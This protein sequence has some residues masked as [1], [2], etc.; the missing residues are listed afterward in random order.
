[1]DERERIWRERI[2]WQQ[3]SGMT[4]VECCDVEG[5]S[6]ASFYR[7]KKLIEGAVQQR[8]GRGEGR[9]M[10]ASSSFVPFT[11]RRSGP[12]QK[13]RSVDSWKSHRQNDDGQLARG[14]PRNSR[15]LSERPLF[16][17]D[18]QELTRLCLRIC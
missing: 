15:E 7:C 14:C 10:A 12:D 6:V 4:V 9:A 8:T 16:M 1:M 13:K 2:A 5:V 18:S 11:L 3:Q 17:D